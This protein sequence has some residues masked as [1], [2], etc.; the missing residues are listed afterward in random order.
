[1]RRIAALSNGGYRQLNRMTPIE[2][3]WSFTTVVSPALALERAEQVDRR[4]FPPVELVSA[5]RCRLGGRI[6]H[7]VPFDPVEMHGLGSRGHLRRAVVARHIVGELLI[8]HART[9]DAFRRNETIGARAYHLGHLLHRIGQRQALRHDAAH[10]R[11]DSSASASR[12]NGFFSRNRIACRM[13]PTPRLSRRAARRRTRR[14]ATSA[15]CWQ[16]SPAPA[17]GCRHGTS[18]P[19]AA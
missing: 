10:V 6:R 2:P 1:M 13:A 4:V 18:G 5:H 9:G 3:A 14:A 12:G 7:N 19:R 8:H 15:G 11:G 16:R 17:P